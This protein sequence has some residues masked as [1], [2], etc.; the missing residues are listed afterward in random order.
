MTTGDL[1]ERV[2]QIYDEWGRGNFRAGTDLYDDNV[3][4]V[5][6]PEFIDPGVHTGREALRNFMHNFLE[7][8]KEITIRAEDIRVVGDSVLVDVVQRGTGFAS[9]IESELRYFQLW[10]FRGGKVIRIESISDPDE[11]REAAGV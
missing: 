7:P 9:G 10:T 1:R 6:R 4:L 11:A 8:W 5:V 3:M 2:L